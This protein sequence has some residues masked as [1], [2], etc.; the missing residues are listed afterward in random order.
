MTT[1]EMKAWI[2][3]AS[4]EDLLHKWRFEPTGSP[5]FQGVIGNY[6]VR[7]MVWKREQVGD[8]EHVRASKAIGWD[9]R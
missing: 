7:K 3:T 4:Y 8:S 1:D 9:H 2:D 6:Y 5:W